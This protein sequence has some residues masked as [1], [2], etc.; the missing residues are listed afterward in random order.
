MPAPKP[1]LRLAFVRSL[2]RVL[3]V[4]CYV[5]G[6]AFRSS[7]LQAMGLPSVAEWSFRRGQMAAASARAVQLLKLA[8]TEP[9]DW[10]HGNAVH[11]GH[12]MLGR[13]AFARGDIAMAEAELLASA[14]TP[15]SPQLSSFGPNMQLALDLLEAGRKD[16]VLEYFRLCEKFWETGQSQLHDWAS[17]IEHG[18]VPSFGGNLLY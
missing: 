4:V 5:V 9:N 16:S 8:E 11:K 1:P 10:N 7:A 6:K 13:V 2:G 17:E 18:R 15:G 3:G 12:L 14:R